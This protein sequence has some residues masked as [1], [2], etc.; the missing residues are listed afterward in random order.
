ML[1]KI[2]NFFLEQPIKRLERCLNC[3]K[4]LKGRQIKFCSNKCNYKYWNRI[5]FSRDDGSKEQIQVK[6][7][8]KKYAEKN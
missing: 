4:K 2:K 3:N 5:R 6:G 7:G 1:N 8:I